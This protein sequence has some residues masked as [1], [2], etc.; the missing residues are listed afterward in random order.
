MLVTSNQITKDG[1]IVD[2]ATLRLNNALKQQKK[3]TKD[4]LA[5]SVVNKA[6]EIEVGYSLRL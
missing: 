2:E 5:N 3:S 4:A 6:V 1:D